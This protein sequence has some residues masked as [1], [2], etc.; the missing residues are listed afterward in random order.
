MEQIIEPVS[1]ELLIAELT[2]QRKLLDTNKGGN[3]LYIF[4]ANEA[5]NLMR[6][7]GR[8]REEAFRMEGGCSGRSMDIDE[9]DTMEQPY[10]QLIVWDPAEQEILGGYR[11]ILGNEISFTAEGR[12]RLATTELF[13]FSDEF[14]NAY[15]PHT[16]ELGRS[17][18]SIGHQSSKAGTKALFA[19]DNLWDG[20]YFLME[21]HP[22]M[23]YLFGK[24]TVHPSYDKGAFELLM[25]FLG[26]HFPDNSR[27]VW[28]KKPIKSGTPD[29]LLEAML[30]DSDY[31]KDYRNLKGAVLKMG[32]YIPPLVNAYMN[33]SATMKYF[34][35]AE[36]YDL[37]GAKEGGILVTFSDVFLSKG[38]RH[39]A[40]FLNNH[41]NALKK[42]FP[43]ID[44][45]LAKNNMNKHLQKKK[46]A[47]QRNF[48]KKLSKR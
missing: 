45:E 30:C 38:E 17:F 6:E 34:G 9:Y 12:P 1:K 32:S 26:K 23:L 27:L 22:Q 35:F 24:V 31:D 44:L 11:Y 7:V 43:S 41:L 29:N 13:D 46:L 5:P 47:A 42:R 19:L 2:P 18:V 40:A 16:M 28:P 20:I 8:L 37:I 39:F 15:L 14:V 33:V 25:H 48:F 4:K 21:S 3:E 10:T 36:C